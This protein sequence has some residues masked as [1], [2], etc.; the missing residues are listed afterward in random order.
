MSQTSDADSQQIPPIEIGSFIALRPDKSEFIGSASGVF[1]ANTVF[2][3]FA[4]ATTTSGG[5]AAKRSQGGVCGL[6]TTAT[7]DPGSAHEYVMAEEKAQEEA[8]VDDDT[9]GVGA[10][11]ADD[12]ASKSPGVPSYGIAA[13]GLG[14][15]PPPAVAK[16]LLVEY[17]RRWH[18]FLPFLHG[19]TFFDKVNRFYEPQGSP[20]EPM[21]QRNKVYQAIIFQCVFNIADSNHNQKQERELPEE[22]RIKSAIALT[23]LLGILSSGHDIPSLQALLAVELYLMTQMS[24]RAASTVHGAMT[25]ILYH[26][27]MH[28]CPFR[29]VQLPRDICEMRK[30]IFWSAYVIDRHL[31]Q[32]LGHPLALNDEE[33][34]VCL[35]GAPEVHNPAKPFQNSP[36]SRSPAAGDGI[37]AYVP[38][39]HPTFGSVSSTGDLTDGSTV[40]TREDS[41]NTDQLVYRPQS[42][43]ES[44]LGFLVTYSR[45]LG[46]ALDLFH[47]S[48]HSRSITWD[49]VLEMTSK[50][51]AWWN[52]LPPPFQ[53][54]GLTS[55]FV[56]PQSHHGPPF[57]ILYHQLILI[58]NRPFLSLPTNRTD[59]QFSLQTAVNASR[60][61]VKKLKLRQGDSPLVAWPGM[62]SAAWMAGLVIAYAGL[63]KLYPMEKTVLDLN[64]AIRL[65]GMMSRN[66]SSAH[67]CRVTLK[68]LLDRLRSKR[69][70]DKI[71]PALSAD[72]SFSMLTDWSQPVFSTYESLLEGSRIKR[73][74]LEHINS[75][76]NNNNN[77]NNNNSSNNNN[78]NSNNNNYFMGN[79]M[80]GYPASHFVGPDTGFISGDN[81]WDYPS[82]Q[83]VLEYT[84]PD[85]G[86]DADQLSQQGEWERFLSESMNP[87]SSGL[88]FNNIGWDTY[89][90]NLGDRLNV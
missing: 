11:G 83:P 67:H 41:I 2:R 21:S 4:T 44:I 50:I 60:A 74:R 5:S 1:F 31:S 55:I 45:L 73:R 24:L 82:F 36:Q 47:K 17:F 35:P 33:I 46:Q 78:N 79:Y 57:A 90:Q 77:N 76:N 64:C 51:H 68:M 15:P 85:F 30:R 54:E 8:A 34:D 14:T 84:G 52:T 23:S 65:L 38:V 26:C 43:G 13:S 12:D 27:G 59:F 70:M 3:A 25:R 42:S 7:P 37:Q 28:R 20:A 88:L 81:F 49:K 89:V 62:L 10:V 32:V 72:P 53:G 19:P 80:S 16:R 87:E 63:L 86:F 9:L 22:S 18:P 75:G 61:I 48:I 39:D 71:N 40:G 66:W 56:E 58:M 6:G 69:F 29:Y